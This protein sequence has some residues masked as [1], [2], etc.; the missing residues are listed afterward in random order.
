VKFKLDENLPVEL[1]A[2]LRVLGHDAE[3]VLD[4]GLRGVADSTLIRVATAEARIL[5]TLDKGIANL[6][7]YPPHEHEGVVLFRPDSSGRRAVLEFMR[8]FLPRLLEMEL[9][10][11]V[12]VAGPLRIR[13]R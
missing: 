8:T 3:T 9:Q 6:L 4:E 1:A 11:K 2:D 5:L 7:Q 12:T 10:K 13:S